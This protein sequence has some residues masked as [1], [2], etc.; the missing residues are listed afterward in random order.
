MPY[1]N[2]P[3]WAKATERLAL[4]LRYLPLFMLAIVGA[5]TNDTL[6]PLPLS[7]LLSATTLVCM[8]GVF[9]RRYHVEW[10]GLSATALVLTI[11]SVVMFP[12]ASASAV[13]LSI[14][15][16]CSFGDRWVRMARESW[17]AR[18]EAEEIDEA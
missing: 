18:A 1:V 2:Y 16:T 14:A 7:I 11:T 4:V 10:V 13:W 3:T 5:I 9:T 6:V 15:L 17:M 12:N 8:I